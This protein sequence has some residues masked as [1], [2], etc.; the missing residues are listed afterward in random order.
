MRQKGRRHDESPRTRRIAAAAGCAAIA[1][2]AALG[3][4]GDALKVWC[5]VTDPDDVTWY[6]LNDRTTGVRGW[7]ETRYVAVSGG[8]VACSSSS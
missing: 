1:G 3:Y 8:V 5:S 4:E 7:S 6:Y 2:L